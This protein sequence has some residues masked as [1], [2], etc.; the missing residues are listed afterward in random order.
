MCALAVQNIRGAKMVMSLQHPASSYV[1]SVIRIVYVG[2]RPAVTVPPIPPP[3]SEPTV[4][5][6]WA[7][8]AYLLDR[9]STFPCCHPIWCWPWN[10]KS[11]N[12]SNHRVTLVFVSLAQAIHC[13]GAWSVNR[14]K[15]HLFKY[16]QSYSMAT[17]IARASRST[18]A[19]FRS[20][21]VI[22]TLT[23]KT[24]PSL[25]S[26]A[27]MCTVKGSEKSGFWRT[28]ELLRAV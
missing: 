11:C 15:C 8:R 13:R 16:Y 14:V 17:F 5:V 7:Q 20:A 6:G 22:F 18:A 21:W 12:V 26:E 3:S 2:C 9:P 25:V 4:G 23:Y 10:E 1:R 19:Y 28:G 24:A 27:S